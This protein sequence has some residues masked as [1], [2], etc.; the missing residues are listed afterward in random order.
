MARR[1]A[2]IVVSVGADA[3]DLIT[4]MRRAGDAVD[5]FSGKAS[6]MSVNWARVGTVVAGAA[7]AMGAAAIALGRDAV[8]T[9]GDLERLSA[10]A[11][12][13]VEDFQK[14]AIAADTVRVSQEK[15]SDIL[16]DVTDRVGDFIATGGGPMRDFFE[17]IAPQV[18]VTA[19]QFAKLGGRDALLLYVDSLEK[20]GVSQSE[21]TFYLEALSSDLTR[22]QPLLANNGAELRRIGDEA[23]R[24]GRVMSQEAVQAASDLDQKFRDMGQTLRQQL[25]VAISDNME[26]LSAFG[27]FAGNAFVALVDL[28][29]GAVGRLVSA[30]Q[31]LNANAEL[32]PA[33]MVAQLESDLDR[34]N[35]Q[36]ASVFDTAPDADRRR[37]EISAE[38]A[39]TAEQLLTLR[40]QISE[41]QA[42]ERDAANAALGAAAGGLLG[43]GVDGA[44][45]GGSLDA[46]DALLKDMS[47]R[48]KA[49]ADDAGSPVSTAADTGGSG[50]GGAGMVYNFDA[51]RDEFATAEEMINEEY[52]RNLARLEEYRQSKLGTEEEYNELERRIEAEHQAALTELAQREQAARLDAIGGALGDAAALMQTENER[53]FQIGKA[54]ATARAVVEGYEAA[55]AAW[56]HG[57]SIGGPPLAAAF[58]AA[59]LARTGAL[60][61]SIQS[62]SIGGGGGGSAGATGGG[63]AATETAAAPAP[64]QVSL[65]GIS[66]DELISGA[67]V[68]ALLER[69]SEEAGDRGFTLV[70]A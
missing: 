1:V 9:A 63:A 60:I 34:L 58:T 3:G 32:G 13:N 53:L 16:K 45:V 66:A 22:L 39:S 20:A 31:L 24:A 17:N 36:Y 29:A 6:R 37:S 4:T 11:N 51:L 7:A 64:L 67:S 38:I 70:S 42:A 61:S 35:A 19:E 46:V 18:G 43:V 26:E 54:A 41:T 5:G 14:M 15:L 30:F 28:A 56:R 33:A 2:D 12:T 68:S 52:A 48:N 49:A 62:Q 55:T 25:L 44:V 50:G 59:S 8:R 21:M 40:Q 27:E 65:T 57:M 10:V 69:L 23:E 47:D